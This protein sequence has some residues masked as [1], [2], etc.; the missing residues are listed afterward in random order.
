MTGGGG[1]GGGL[2]ALG[3]TLRY[4]L[5]KVWL[6]RYSPG[7]KKAFVILKPT[8]FKGNGVFQ[9]SLWYRATTSLALSGCPGSSGTTTKGEG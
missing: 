8:F 9:N 1:G 5:W 6:S 3:F 7:E 4:I 2:A